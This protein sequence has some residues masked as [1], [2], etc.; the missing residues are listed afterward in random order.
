MTRKKRSKYRYTLVER[1]HESSRVWR[2]RDQANSIVLI[3]KY[4]LDNF[5]IDL[6]D[7]GA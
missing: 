7:G 6:R 1:K 2:L 5:G 3:D 4:L